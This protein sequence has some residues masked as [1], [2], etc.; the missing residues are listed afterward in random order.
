[1]AILEQQEPEQPAGQRLPPVTRL[2]HANYLGRE[3]QRAEAA[4]I[5]GEAYVQD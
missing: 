1:M 4:L 3:F 5:S 2:E